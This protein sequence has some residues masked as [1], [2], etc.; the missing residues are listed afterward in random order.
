MRH[1]GCQFFCTRTNELKF[2]WY[3]TI[4]CWRYDVD[5]C[6]WNTYNEFV[7][8]WKSCFF[9]NCLSFLLSCFFVM[10]FLL[11]SLFIFKKQDTSFFQ[12]SLFPDSCF[13]RL[14]SYVMLLFYQYL[15]ARIQLIINGHL[16]ETLSVILWISIKLGSPLTS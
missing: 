4:S 6:A 12:I 1:T 7:F 14:Y 13:C 9:I 16:L 10:C 8:V 11:L 15:Y 3:N 5:I 2:D